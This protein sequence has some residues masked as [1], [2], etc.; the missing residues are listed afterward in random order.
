MLI[1]HERDKLINVI[2]FFAKN[3]RNLGKVKLYKLLYF[4]DFQHYR[5][6]GRPVTGLQYFAWPMGP[7][8]VAL[9]KEVRAPAADM[10]EKVS[11]VLSSYKKGETLTVTPKV[12]F[13]PGHF[14][15]RE[16]KL[17]EALADE[18]RHTIAID[19]IE[20]TH[21]ENAPW[22]KIYN[23]QQRRQHAIPYALAVCAREAEELNMIQVEHEEIRTNFR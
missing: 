1:E 23:I 11:L 18:F 3:T 20:R 12:E 19:M 17:M 22:D 21:L 13:N 4:L 15:K 8:P 2:I 16:L 10:L 7:V 9:E 6:V 5:D 14:S